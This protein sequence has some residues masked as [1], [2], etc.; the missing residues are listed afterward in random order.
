MLRMDGSQRLEGGKKRIEYDYI[1][2]MDSRNTI[3]MVITFLCGC[4][5]LV[6]SRAFEAG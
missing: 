2:T 1:L 6:E 4:R 3:N 5:C